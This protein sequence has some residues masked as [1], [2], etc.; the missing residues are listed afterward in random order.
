MVVDVVDDVV[1][2]DVVEEVDVVVDDVVEEVDVVVEVELVDED[3][4]WTLD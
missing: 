3:D 1:V 4:D 2:D